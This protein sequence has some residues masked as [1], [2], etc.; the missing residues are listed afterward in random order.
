MNTLR[1][2]VPLLLL[3]GCLI[4]R[5]PQ[6]VETGFARGRMRTVETPHVRAYYPE[7]GRDTAL[8]TLARLEAC[9]AS[10]ATHPLS[11]RQREKLQVFFT[12]SNFNNAY[13]QPQIAG[14]PQQMV[15]PQQFSLELF[16]L[17]GLA[18]G[19]VG[20]VSCHEAVHYVHMQEATGFWAAVNTVLGNVHQPNAFSDTWFLE[21]LATWYE[22]RLGRRVGRPENPLWRGMFLSYAATHRLDAGHLNALHREHLPF[23]AQYLVGQHFVEWLAR[24]HGEEK[25]WALV[26][27]QGDAIFSSL[28]F[29]LRFK[30]VYGQGI[31]AEFDV[32][33]EELRKT[34]SRRERP[35]GQ[36]VRVSRPAPYFAR[37]A[38]APDGS[39]ALWSAALDDVNRLSVYAP[40]GALRWTRRLAEVL[41]GRRWISTNPLG[42]SG[43]SFSAD[44]AH[45]GFALADVTPMGNDATRLFVLDAATGEVLREAGPFIG[46]GGTL[47]PD[48]TCFVAVAQ[49]GARSQLVSMDVTTGATTALTRFETPE[50]LASPAWSPD[51]AR[52]AFNRWTGE[53]FDLWLREADGALRPVTTDGRFNYQPRWSG[54]DA[55]VFLRD[56][57][58]RAQPWRC[59]L[60]TGQLEQL[61]EVPWAAL[62][63]HPL[64][65]GRVLLLNREGAAFTV[66]ELAGRPALATLDS[67]PSA[68]T[69]PAGSAPAPS[70]PL[71]L[72]GDAPYSAW[73]NLL[74]P[75]LRFPYVGFTVDGE[76]F[77]PF[78]LLG[79][80]GADR[81]GL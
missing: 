52:V 72:S 22:A 60:S 50:T 23:G 70:A 63:P 42:V 58:G 77:R 69:P 29:T 1:L 37:L 75:G 48:G 76:R 64:P 31:G 25:L 33:A 49:D 43:L 26:A 71:E 44:G 56:T 45:L 78:Y 10:L 8:R 14:L 68:S 38:T 65:G 9:T 17:L 53:G 35:A 5:F 57:E 61:G 30:H 18:G 74:V 67:K 34:V 15:L 36:S 12:T 7:A 46:L 28:G 3:A 62:D 2:A 4:P 59:T 41:P 39:F 19:E 20:D 6:D 51:G 47:S 21:G 79:L 80:S 11:R 27:D 32:F 55:L 40:S 66:D 54:E 81:L 16:H 13:V 24:R 73:D